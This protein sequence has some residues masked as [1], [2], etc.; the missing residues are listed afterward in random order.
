M[1]EVSVLST[2]FRPGGIDVLLAGMRDQT[3]RDFE[4]ILVDRRYELR[5]EK[6][7]E[8]A[9]RY[10]VPL[11]HVP[12]HRRNGK[13]VS[14]C[15]AW[16]T[17][18][19]LARGRVIL[20][21]V[22]YAYAPPGW[23]ERHLEVLGDR[24]RYVTG[25][26]RMLGLPPLALKHPYDFHDQEVASHCVSVDRILREDLLD[27]VCAFERPFEPEW[28]ETFEVPED[29]QDLRTHSLDRQAGLV[30][31]AGWVHVK[32]ESVARQVAWDL[33][34]LD[35]RLERGRGPMDIDWQWRLTLA[36]VEVWWEPSVVVWYLDSHKV[37]AALPW[38][39]MHERVEGRWSWDDGL[40]Y[41]ERRKVDILWE[42]GSRRALNPYSM[43]DLA[44]RLE[45]W[46]T[47]AVVPQS[48]DVDDMTY[49]GS[50]IWPHSP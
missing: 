14:F 4:V 43:E 32:N 16:N 1:P 33:N 23:V 12:E 19:A 47:G 24:R 35:E 3:F 18:M 31:N 28:G 27:E 36:G 49:W 50:D 7:M 20:F 48:V 29:Q 40:Q 8:L 39:S 17:A 13:W 25:S 34:G 10:G 46:R 9:K 15:S 2:A 21:L 11:L 6:V 22:D 26:Y 30:L 42:R 38:G 45:P 41:V 5:H 37:S 44:V